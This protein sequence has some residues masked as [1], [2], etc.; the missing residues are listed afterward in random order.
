MFFI[1]FEWSRIL[2]SAM[3]FGNDFANNVQKTDNFRQV[4]GLLEI[5]CEIQQLGRKPSQKIN[6]DVTLH[7]ISLPI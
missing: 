5:V 7:Y 4:F 3:D 6:Y 1:V 2:E